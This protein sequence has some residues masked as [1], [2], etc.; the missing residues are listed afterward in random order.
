MDLKNMY[1]VLSFLGPH[2]I[3][4]TSLETDC[5]C[6]AFADK[7]TTA[8]KGSVVAAQGHTGSPRVTQEHTEPGPVP[9]LFIFNADTSQPV[10]QLPP[11]RIP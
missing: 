5:Y 7:E 3:L 8:Q 6:P 11:A 2:L 4:T 10:S 1:Y 9:G